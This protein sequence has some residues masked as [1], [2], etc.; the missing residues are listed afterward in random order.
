MGYIVREYTRYETSETT[1]EVI[2]LSP[3]YLTRDE[4]F[5][6]YMEMD[7]PDDPNIFIDEIVHEEE[8]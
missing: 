6:D 1:E 2:D 8:C 5:Q 7:G 3:E 4:A